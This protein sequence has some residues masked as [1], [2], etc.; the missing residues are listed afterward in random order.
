MNKITYPIRVMRIITR[1][2]IGGPAIHV[3]NLNA[4]LDSSRYKSLLVTGMEAESEGSFKDQALAKG[5]RMEVLPELGRELSLKNDWVTI[6]K[7]YHLMKRD[8]P[9]IVHTH[10]AK[11]GF[12]GRLAARLARVP[13][14]CHTFH[15]HV[16][17]S[18]FG[19]LK[20]RL[21]IK[22]EKFGARLSTRIITLSPSLREELV[23][24]G[25][26]HPDH[27]S[28][29]PL[30]FNL[31]PFEEQVRNHGNFRKQLGVD[32]KTALVGAVGRLVKIKNL[33]LFLGA[34]AR[35]RQVRSDIQFVLVG[36]GE[37]RTALEEL[38]HILGLEAAVHFT[39]WRQDLPQIYAD[40][41]AAV[42]SSDNEGTPVSLIEAMSAGCP[43][44]ATRVGGVP[45]LLET[46]R[47][48]ILVPPGNPKAL[49]EA[50]LQVASDLRGTRE[51]A[52]LAKKRVIEKF[53]IKRLVGD[54]DQLYLELLQETGS[55]FK[56]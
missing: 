4:G 12:V 40:L 3:I 21:F 5:L 48:G 37:E 22:L 18:Y 47:L 34:I 43:V 20:T 41:D 14:V 32:E 1:L 35:V 39:G 6:W 15:G 51:R 55:R 45:D 9:Q 25:V 28:E 24:L 29:I 49:A 26:T 11:A 38:V 46:G 30:G 19:S 36:D 42:I 54:M 13:V 16:L 56:G 7:L 33:P 8:R 44:I 27:V 50:I 31:K 53:S 23:Q 17:H 2:N 10:T 52:S